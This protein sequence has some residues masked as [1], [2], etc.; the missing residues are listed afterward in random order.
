MLE[1][2][3]VCESVIEEG[4][5]EDAHVVQM[6]EAVPFMAVVDGHGRECNADGRRLEHSVEVRNFAVS[7]AKTLS[8]LFARDQNPNA[9]S[10]MFEEAHRRID[11][12]K[13]HLVSLSA[14]GVSSLG[15]SVSAVATVG[16]QIH[17]AQVGDCRLYKLDQRGLHR[18]T[19][20]H[21]PDHPSEVQRLRGF[22]E[23]GEITLRFKRGVSRLYRSG[24]PFG[25]MLTR[26]FG[27]WVYGDALA[28]VPEVQ[29]FPLDPQATYA[30]CSDGG[31][32]IV[33][34]S[35]CQGELCHADLESLE[36]VLS[37]EA[38]WPEDDVTIVLFRQ[39]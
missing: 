14:P 36:R 34:A 30:L 9:L 16:N 28:H 20:D 5:S 29:E 2:R 39:R 22:V 3:V 24:F 12:W 10:E 6:H 38:A 15:A 25:L 17:L 35:Y 11:H 37:A 13:D 8:D 21:H 31:A 26:S 18:L 32:E 1:C 7:I 33:E 19:L 27:D 4:P 23:R